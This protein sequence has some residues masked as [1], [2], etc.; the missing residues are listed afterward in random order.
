MQIALALRNVGGNRLYLFYNGSGGTD[1]IYAQSVMTEANRWYHC[2]FV[3]SGSTGK[4]YVDGQEVPTLNSADFSVNPGV[5]TTDNNMTLGAWRFGGGTTSLLGELSNVCVWGTALTDGVGGQIEQLYNNGVPLSQLS[6]IPQAANLKGWYKLNQSANWE[7]NSALNWQIPDNRSAYPQSFNFSKTPQEYINLGNEDFFD[8]NNEMTFS[9][10]VNKKDW[11]STGFEGIISKYGTAGATIQYRI[12]YP[13]SAG[14]LQF[15]LQGGPSGGPY[16]ARIDTVTL[17]SAQQDS[18]WLHILWRHDA[19]I[20]RSEV[21]FNGDYTNLVS[22]NNIAANPYAQPQTT[23]T[24]MIGNVSNGLQPFDG[25]ISN[26]QRFNSYLDNATV[27]ALYN[28][29]VPSTTAVAPTSSQAWYKLDNTETYLKPDPSQN[30]N[31]YEAWLVENQKYPASVDKCLLFGQNTYIRYDNFDLINESELTVSFWFLHDQSV[32]SWDRV[33]GSWDNT[34]YNFIINVG[35]SG[36][37]NISCTLRTNAGSG[38]F[39]SNNVYFGNVSTPTVGW[40]LLTMTYNGSVIKAYVNNE[41]V[42]SLSATGT[43]YDLNPYIGGSRNYYQ[44][45]RDGN[46]SADGMR[47]SNVIY[48]NKAL[49]PSEITTLYNNGTPLLTKDSIPQDSSMLLWNTLENKTETIGG[50][51]YDKSG[52]STSIQTIVNSSNIAVD[53]VPVSAKS[54]LSSG[55]TYQSLVNNNVSVVNGESDGMNST[56]LVT[57]NLTRTQPYSNYSFNF[58]RASSDYFDLGTLQSTALQPSDATLLSDG[59]SVSMWVNLRSVNTM[60]LWQNDGLGQTNYAGLLLQ[61]NSGGQINFG[62][63]DNTGAGSGDRLTM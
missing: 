21:I 16:G 42:D 17:T 35:R 58:D 39:V 23:T 26:Y 12:A 60:G 37:P 59:F 18:E 47:M 44:S 51:L 55:M 31:L 41:E 25:A 32:N 6:Q 14:K 4:L 9:L 50:G 5:T 52:N 63:S 11:S 15:Y 27:E 29:G 2:A 10:W 56:N 22:L 13:S 19:N 43:V 30:S 53:N 3:R 38:G 40:R 8:G 45:I 36:A 61:I 28:E 7:A 1:Y 20:G 57:S 33:L 24:N 54:V 49:I 34:A 46:G 62:Y 48:W